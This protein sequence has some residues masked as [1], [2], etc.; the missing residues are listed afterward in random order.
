MRV[1]SLLFVLSTFFTSAC[2]ATYVE[3]ERRPGYEDVRFS[4][5]VV[6]CESQNDAVREDVERAFAYSVG[7]PG[8]VA[9][10]SIEVLNEP[11]EYSDEETRTIMDGRGFD[12]LVR[13][14]IEDWS[15]ETR[16][17]PG[18]TTT[19]FGPYGVHVVHDPPHASTS[20]RLALAL[21][22]HDRRSGGEAWS[23]T[24]DAES[25]G[26][27]DLRDLARAAGG[28]LREHLWKNHL[29]GR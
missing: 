22:L 19:Y 29:I 9:V 6:Y 10:P 25:G 5:I 27:R 26:H 21:T 20:T 7:G 3:G 17:Y 4:K 28:R 24:A 14:R 2:V 11:R 12:G 23:G 8:L 16:R 15:S 1:V 13:I 18:A